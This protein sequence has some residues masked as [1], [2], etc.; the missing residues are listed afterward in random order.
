MLQRI[1]TQYVHQST[2]A[3]PHAVH[4]GVAFI[5]TAAVP[6]DESFHRIAVSDNQARPE[7][8]FR[9]AFDV[10]HGNHIFQVVPAPLHRIAGVNTIAKPEVDGSA[11]K[12]GGQIVV[13]QPGRMATAKSKLT[14]EWTDTTRGVESPA[15]NRYAF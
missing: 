5:H 2:P 1:K 7:H 13:C 15:S 4:K 9:H 12:Y 10:A 6:G 3:S 8:H 11:T 14:T